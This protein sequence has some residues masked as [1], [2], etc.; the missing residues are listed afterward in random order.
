MN[1]MKPFYTWFNFVFSTSLLLIAISCQ[2]CITD[3]KD[4]I[5][6]QDIVNVNINQVASDDFL[7]SCTNLKVIPLENSEFSIIGKLKKVELKGNKIYILDGK[8]NS[9]KC[10]TIEGEFVEE[11]S[12]LGEGPGM[13][14]LLTD[15][16]FNHYTNK[17]EMLTPQGGLISYDEA[18]GEFIKEFNLDIKSVAFFEKINEDL[19]VFYSLFEKY[20]LICYSRKKNEVV[21]RGLPN[22]DMDRLARV[23]IESPFFKYQEEVR[24]FDPQTRKMFSVE[25]EG[26]GK[27][28]EF[29]FGK[30]NLDFEKIPSQV[31]AHPRGFLEYLTEESIAYPIRV[32]HE[33]EDYLF[34]SAIYANSTARNYRLDK[35]KKQ[36]EIIN[37]PIEHFFKPWIFYTS[38]EYYGFFTEPKGVEAALKDL[39][40]VSLPKGISEE[41]NPIMLRYSLCKK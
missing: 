2:S 39:K 30:A 15:I 26:L 8:S 13:Y 40:S 14:Y 18:T 28:M 32:D 21:Y 37:L 41:D 29:D 27:M 9:V 16:A 38:E 10:F 36:L 5:K 4:E 25:P 23:S 35:G 34:M 1:W 11:I 7:T 24:V 33:D 3:Q 19:V 6:Y 20:R 22:L 31:S 12:N 17:L